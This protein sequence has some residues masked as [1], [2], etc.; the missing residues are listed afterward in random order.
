MCLGNISRDFSA[1]NM[2]KNKP[3]PLKKTTNNKQTNKQKNKNKN[4][5][6]QDWMNGCTVFLLIVELL[7]LVILSTFI[8]ILMKEHDIK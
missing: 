5:K 3:P 8:K 1:Y 7:I 6:T 2:K 4:K